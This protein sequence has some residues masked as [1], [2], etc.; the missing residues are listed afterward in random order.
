MTRFILTAAAVLAVCVLALQ[1]GETPKAPA[2][3]F[4]KPEG[5]YAYDLGA[6]EGEA[7]LGFDAVPFDRAFRDGFGLVF[8]KGQKEVDKTFDRRTDTGYPTVLEGTGVLA[9]DG[10]SY[11]FTRD[12]PDGRYVCTA[13]MGGMPKHHIANFNHVLVVNGKRV[14]DGE[15]PINELVDKEFFRH[16]EAT[17]VTPADLKEPGR[18][19]YDLYI[20]PVWK[21]HDFEA[22]IAGG[23][24][25]VE[26]KSG[27][28]NALVITPAAKEA[29][30]QAAMEKL[31]ADREREFVARW[32]KLV[33]NR[34]YQGSYIPTAA[35]KQRGYVV[36][37]R[38]WMHKVEHDSRPDPEWV[39]TT[40]S[41]AAT[42]GEFEPV[43]FSLWPL[44]DLP[45]VSVTVGEG[46]GD[47][48]A[49]LPAQTIRVWYLQQRQTRDSEAPT[50]YRIMSFYLPDWGPGRDLFKDMV[51]RCWLSIHVPADA[52]PGLYTFP[53]RVT[54]AGR[55]PT[56]L[57][58]S[59]RVL[60]FTLERPERMHSMRAA[61][62]WHANRVMML[63]ASWP[64]KENDTHNALYYRKQAI[65]HLA[66]NGLMPEIV[67]RGKP[68]I[69]WDT[70]AEPLSQYLAVLKASPLGK[71]GMLW[72]DAG[73]MME[74]TLG[75]SSV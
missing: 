26:I 34:S 7:A 41:A 31:D 56:E 23:R 46:K 75:P 50:T 55:E 30:H 28:L 57:A 51:Q 68:A 54:P 9:Q 48:G 74:Q 17:L 58:L 72:V 18:R 19:I 15:R 64:L 69:E 29:D 4:A 44:A 60:P 53:V 49:K 66:E 36:F 32:A 43:T 3:T 40:L 10:R 35:D 1:A 14:V 11:T 38:H 27:Q 20:R 6:K 52:K 33:P 65:D 22:T 16:V 12:L 42:P 37:R 70:G 21:R 2:F 13:Y 63:P 67:V 8:T 25:T 5:A 24:L 45:K 59:L 62:T 61:G 47:G 39:G 73:G 71:Q